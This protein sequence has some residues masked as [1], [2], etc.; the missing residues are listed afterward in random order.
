MEDEPKADSP[1]AVPVG[2]GVCPAA[3][4]GDRAEGNMNSG[5]PRMGGGGDGSSD[6]TKGLDGNEG[7]TPAM[8]GEDELNAGSSNAVLV[9]K[10][11]WGAAASGTCAGAPGNSS[12][13][14]IGGGEG[15][16]KFSNGEWDGAITVEAD[17]EVKAGSPNAVLVG[18]GAWFA[19]ASVAFRGGNGTTGSPGRGGGEGGNISVPLVDRPA[20]KRWDKL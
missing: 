6:G 11:A 16:S 1:Q 17:D 20:K 15:G 13:P 3:G 10:R 2:K 19:S 14:G 7:A 4:S 9:G 12:S 5:S 8:D 18:T